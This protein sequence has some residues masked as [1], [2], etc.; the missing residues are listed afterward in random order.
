MW[1]HPVD[2]IGTTIMC[3]SQIHSFNTFGQTYKKMTYISSDVEGQRVVLVRPR[4][5]QFGS[6]LTTA[7]AAAE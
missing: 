4:D 2:N 5:D 3:S 7:S 1:R 6:V